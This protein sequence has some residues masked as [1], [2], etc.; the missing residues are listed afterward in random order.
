MLIVFYT[1]FCSVS[2]LKSVWVEI[3]E[4]LVGFHKNSIQKG[5]VVVNVGRLCDL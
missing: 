3:D 2:N 5:V 4:E 1:F